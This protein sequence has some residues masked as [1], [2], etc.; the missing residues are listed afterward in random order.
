MLTLGL[1][2]LGPQEAAAC[3][4]ESRRTN[5]SRCKIATEISPF[6]GLCIIIVVHLNILDRPTCTR[7]C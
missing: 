1:Q 2:G 7:I 4:G 3:T 5:C 6:D